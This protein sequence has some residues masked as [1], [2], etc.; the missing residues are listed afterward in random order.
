MFA[1]LPVATPPLLEMC[2]TRT[3]PSSPS[4]ADDL[5]IDLQKQQQVRERPSP[6][7][8]LRSPPLE[9]LPEAPHITSVSVVPTPR[10]H[11]GCSQVLWQAQRRR[12]AML[13][14]RL[15]RLAGVL[16]HRHSLAPPACTA[17][18]MPARVL[19]GARCS[20]NMMRKMSQ[21]NSRAATWSTRSR[22]TWP[23]RAQHAVQRGARA[24]RR[25]RKL[26]CHHASH[27]CA[28]VALKPWA[29][30]EAATCRRARGSCSSAPALHAPRPAPPR[31]AW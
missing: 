20:S 29:T 5:I 21:E 19:P 24:V 23:P 22:S 31:R 12:Y 4:G 30:P 1:A 25:G 3:E 13:Y 15:Q 27:L 10:E 16:S 7:S 28:R 8:T 9:L 14:D 6:A 17:A 26:Q 18:L 2:H 11:P